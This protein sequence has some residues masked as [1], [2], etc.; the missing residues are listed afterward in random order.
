MD[1]PARRRGKAHGRG[2][3][4]VAPSPAVSGAPPLRENGGRPH[5]TTRKRRLRSSPPRLY[6]APG[7]CG[8]PGSCRIITGREWEERYAFVVVDVSGRSVALTEHAV[9][10][11][12]GGPTGLMLAAELALAGIDVVIVERR[13]SQDVDGSRG[14]AFLPHDRGARSAWHRRSVPRG[15]AGDAGPG[16]AGIPLDISDFPTA[17]TTDLRSGRAASSPSWLAGSVSWGFRSSVAERWWASLKTTSASMSKCPTARRS[18]GVSRRL[19]RR[20]Q[21]GP[22]QPSTSPGW[23]PRPAG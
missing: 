21:P 1:R 3:L 7:A 16:F 23:I 17:T 10:I 18:D 13:T 2:P 5:R 12:G 14:G 9:V 19:R 8:K 4:L 22:G 15:G 6:S 11:A 20:T